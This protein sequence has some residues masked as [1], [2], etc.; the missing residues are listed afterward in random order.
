[1]FT[2]RLLIT[3]YLHVALGFSPR[4]DLAIRDNLH[5]LS[6]SAQDQDAGKLPPIIR[7]AYPIEVEAAVE[8]MSQDDV[9]EPGGGA[10]YILLLKTKTSQRSKAPARYVRADFT[11]HQIYFDPKFEQMHDFLFG[12]K[13]I[14]KIKL[15]PVLG[16]SECAYPVP[17]PPKPGE[18]VGGVHIPIM[19]PAGDAEAY[20][21]I[22]TLPCYAFELK[23][24]EEVLL[25]NKGK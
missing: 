11:S 2:T 13:K 15:H 21:D 17:A 8:A 5:G 9:G 16:G 10:V 25:P 4:I 23:D 1:M 3:A 19:I 20:P 6:G 12:K 14:W 18:I 7:A 22:N 24:I